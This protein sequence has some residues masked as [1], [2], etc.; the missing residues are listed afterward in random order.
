[1]VRESLM[2][3]CLK[4]KL[5]MCA[6]QVCIWQ[7]DR[8]SVKKK[9]Q[10]AEKMHPILICIITLEI[11]NSVQC[12]PQEWIQNRK[13]FIAFSWHSQSS[14]FLGNIL[15]KCIRL[16]FTVPRKINQFGCKRYQ[17]KRE[18][19]GY[20]LLNILF[21]KF[22]VVNESWLMNCVAAIKDSFSTYV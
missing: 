17:K 5:F 13:Y 18:D 12:R 21:S 15:Q 19:V 1:M 7:H 3:S 9:M 11:P 2:W 14:F 16:R 10:Y 8:W 20:K 6:L 22:F 4:R